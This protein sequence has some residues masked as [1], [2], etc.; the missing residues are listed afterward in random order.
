MLADEQALRERLG[1]PRNARRVILFGETSHWDPNW[2]LTSEQ[3]YRRRIPR[4]FQEVIAELEKEPRRVFGIE[5]LFFLRHYWE[6]KPARREQLA[7]LIG[8]GRLRLTGTGITTPDTNLPDSEAIIRDYLYGQ[9]WLREQGLDVEPRIAYLPDDFGCSPDLP[10]IL[11][12]M[13][14]EMAGITRI[15]GMY[16][17]GTDYRPRSAYPLPGSS[18]ELLQNELRTADFIWRASDGS[19][20]LCHWNAFGYFQGDLIATLGVAR[21]MGIEFGLPWR[22]ERHVARRINAFVAQLERLYCT[23]YMFCPM[24]CDF[25]GPVPDLVGLLDRYNRTCYTDSGVWTA[26]AGMD[27]YLR[28]VSCHRD[29]LPALELDPNP[30]WMGCYATRPEVKIRCGRVTRKLKRAEALAVS[31]PIC[32]MKLREAW[33]LLVLSN[34]HD[35]ITGT[36]PDRIWKLEQRPWLQKSEAIVDQVKTGAA[37]AVSKPPIWRLAAGRLEVRSRHYRVQL[38]EQ[39]G[40]CITSFQDAS[41]RELLAAPANDLVEYRDSGGLW[42]FGHEYRGGVFKQCRRSSR[43][44]ARIRAKEVDGR[45]EVRVESKLGYLPVTRWLWFTED[46]PVIRM[47]ISGSAPRRATIACRFPTRLKSEDM[48]MDVPGGVV[49]RPAHKLF[50]PTYWPARSFAHFRGADRGMAVFFAGLGCVSSDGGG[51]VEWV[52][53]RNA[54]REVA[55]GFLPILAHP[56]SGTDTDEHE[57]DYAVCLTPSGDWRKNRLP[58]TA[59]QVL[60]DR[61]PP[62]DCLVT[63]EGQ[64]LLVQAVKPAEAGPGLIVRIASFGPSTS[65]ARISSRTGDIQSAFLCDALERDLQEIG[66]EDGTVLVPLSFSLVTVRLSL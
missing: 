21:W 44:R 20:V 22:S 10:A 24:G 63:V 18:A 28:L 30:Y 26:C 60:E 42:R 14:I 61:L 12:A 46:Y 31:D 1:I 43:G 33:N 17:V 6:R 55:F 58:Q 65:Q 57:V 62:A 52:V 16:F 47:R 54:P 53:L 45:L 56:A 27:D 3:Y 19:E 15:D 51:S 13:G 37:P 29:R 41:G 34:H 23:P 2:L 49:R 36:S 50:D 39:V 5:S 59:A 32:Q 35:F 7:R 66:V 40:G 8:E 4:I 48:H 9:Q 25:N 11:R 38:S 64:D